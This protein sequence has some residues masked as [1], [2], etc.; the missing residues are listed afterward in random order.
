MSKKPY[1]YAA[2]A[3]YVAAFILSMP[4]PNNMNVYATTAV[5]SIPIQ[6]IDGWYVAG[7]FSVVMLVGSLIY[8]ARSVEKFRAVAVVVPLV[9]FLVLPSIAVPMYQAYFADGMNAL[10]YDKE[11]S[12]CQVTQLDDQQAQLYCE[13]MMKN[14]SDEDVAIA[15][16]FVET[17]QSDYIAQ[18]LNDAGPFE[19]TVGA[20]DERAIIIDQKAQITMQTAVLASQPL[21]IRIIQDGKKRTM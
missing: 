11:Q 21:N 19:V 5:L 4:Y 8:F 1:L 3:L 14:Y 6:T 20:N 7:I 15:I 12:A 10:S 17:K 2:I 13:L 16:E 18:L 9:L